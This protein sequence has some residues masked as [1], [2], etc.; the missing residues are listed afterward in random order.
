M[1]HVAGGINV[2]QEADAGNHH[3]HDHGQ[4]IHLKV[5][6]RAEERAAVDRVRHHDPVKVLLVN[7]G[8]AGSKKFPHG[9]ERAGKRNPSSPE[10]DAVHPFIRPFRAEQAVG[11]RTEQRQQWNDPQIIEHGRVGH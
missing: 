11:C 8:L 2:N 10:G 9:F 3:E 1:R 6:A 7:E 5:E 4:L